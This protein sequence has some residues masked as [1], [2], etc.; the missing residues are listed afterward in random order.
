MKAHALTK[1]CQAGVWALSWKVKKQLCISPSMVLGVLCQKLA[2]YPPQ[3]QGAG[4]EAQL[5]PSFC[6]DQGWEYLLGTPGT[7]GSVLEPNM[8]L[9]YLKKLLTKI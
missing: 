7:T 1:H 5:L 2:L 6:M 8:L 3:P 4:L 9:E